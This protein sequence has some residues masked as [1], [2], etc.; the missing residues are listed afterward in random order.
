MKRAPAKVAEHA[1]Q[2]LSQHA[3]QRRNK[4]V[5]FDAHVQEPHDY[6]DHVVGVD[7]GKH[8]VTGQSRLNGD[9]G[10]LFVANFTD[11]YLVGIVAQNRSQAAGEGQSFLLVH[12]YLGN[13]VQLVFNRIF[14]G[15]DLVFFVADFIQRRVQRR[16]L[17]GTGRSRHQ[18]H[19]VRLS[20]VTAKLS[21]VIR[22]ETDYVQIQVAKLFVDLF[23]V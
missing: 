14:N 13:A 5:R 8:L 1:H 2:P 12:R 17:T 22:I 3:I 4:V 11:H 18:N 10:S 7:G 9:L 16:R 6:V 23:L 21:Q 19:A 15:D 20:D